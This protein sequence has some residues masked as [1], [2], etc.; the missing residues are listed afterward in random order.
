M[1]ISSSAIIAASSIIEP[2]VIIGPRVVIGPFCVISAGV[3]IGEGTC[4][5][6]H[7]II[8][9]NTKIGRDNQIGRGSSI[10]EISQDLKYAGEP[11]GLEIGN[12]NQIGCHATLHRGTVQGGGMTRIG[13]LNIF[14]RGVHLGHDCQ[15]G[16]ATFIGE[17]SA[18]AGHVLL[19]NDARIDALCAVHQFC[20]IGA[21][22]RLLANTCVVQDVPPFVMAGGNRAVPKGI[23]EQTAEFCRAGSSQQNI[24]RYLYDLLYH[25]Q[26]TIE[27]VKSEIERLSTEY[28]LLCHFNAFFLHSARGIIR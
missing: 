22:A 5:S 20:I 28:P 9:G 27:R 12:G 26:E 19:G 17:H 23:N 15:V 16:N 24:I 8:N 1:L 10:G 11:T 7:V 25:R 4:I 13:H 3:Q 18:L 21:G 14:E 6:S 2:G